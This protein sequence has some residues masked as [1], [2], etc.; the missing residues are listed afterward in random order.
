MDDRFNCN[1]IHMTMEDFYR[2]QKIV[3]SVKKQLS[4]IK[5][6]FPWQKDVP[7]LASHDMG[8]TWIYSVSKM[9]VLIERQDIDW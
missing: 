8:F 9:K 3:P 5:K 6:K 4:T 2:R 1:V 7:V